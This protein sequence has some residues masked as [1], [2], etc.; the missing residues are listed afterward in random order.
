MRQHLPYDA[1]LARIDELRAR[2]DA[3]RRARPDP[4]ANRDPRSHVPATACIAIRRAAQADAGAL[5]GLAGLDGARLQPGEVLL[6]EV[7]DE[8]QAAIHVASG[9]TIAD[10]FRPTA[11]LLALLRLRAARLREAHDLDCRPG[12]R[13]RLRS[14]LRAA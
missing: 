5:Q 13:A 1:N 3:S 9:A 14:L 8:L 2:A 6:A 12:L 11:D 4:S 7:G 10:P